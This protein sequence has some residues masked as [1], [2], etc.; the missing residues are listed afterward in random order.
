MALQ[1]NFFS[2]IEIFGAVLLLSFLGD[3]T[4]LFFFPVIQKQ[5]FTVETELCFTILVVL[6][7]LCQTYFYSL[8]LLKMNIKFFIFFFFLFL[9]IILLYVKKKRK[10]ILYIVP[11]KYF[12]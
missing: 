12:Y 5:A 11:K 4:F 7:K 10:G 3:Y 8:S 1:F 9:A 2:K 6:S